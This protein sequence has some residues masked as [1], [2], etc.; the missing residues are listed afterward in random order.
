MHHEAISRRHQE[1]ETL[2]V[3]L[4]LT[5]YLAVTYLNPSR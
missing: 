4:Q 3:E 5:I 2:T 1:E